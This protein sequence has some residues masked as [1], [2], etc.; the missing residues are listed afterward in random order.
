MAGNKHNFVPRGAAPDGVHPVMRDQHGGVMVRHPALPGAH[1]MAPRPD[2][3][4]APPG[5]LSKFNPAG[6]ITGG[7]APYESDKSAESGEYNS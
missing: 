3:I 6:G 4:E 7:L 1:M 2:Y 5:A